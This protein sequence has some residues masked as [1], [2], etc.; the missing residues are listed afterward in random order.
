MRGVTWRA[1]GMCEMKVESLRMRNLMVDPFGSGWVGTNAWY[2][3]ESGYLKK[4]FF[5]M[6][7]W[8]NLAFALPTR[9]WYDVGAETGC[10]SLGERAD[11]IVYFF[12]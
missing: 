1:A 11:F 12:F 8:K 4:L 6:P 5:D 10:R 9:H 7:T 3:M 2:T